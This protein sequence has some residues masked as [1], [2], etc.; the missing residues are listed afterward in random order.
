MSSKSIPKLKRM[1]KDEKD[2]AILIL[3]RDG[4]MDT[5]ISKEIGMPRQ[6]VQLRRSKMGLPPNCIF[7]GKKVSDEQLIRAV[8]K[9]MT[10]S[11]MSALFGMFDTS[12]YRR[13]KK[14]GYYDR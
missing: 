14:L 7:H 12:I 1:P 13:L 6:T 9:G 4:M 2:L 8:E 5:E 11:E 10:V 3:W